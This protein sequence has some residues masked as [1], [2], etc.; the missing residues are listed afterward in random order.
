MC[1]RSPRGSQGRSPAERP[2]DGVAQLAGGRVAAEVLRRR[3]FEGRS[4]ALLLRHGLER[5]AEANAVEQ[6]VDAALD[7]APT[8]D[9][10]GNA[11]TREMGDAVL[12]S[13]GE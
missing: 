7:E 13:L 6:A 10:G 12:R 5:E 9:L 3:L 2:Q 11:T 4:T 8:Q 1:G